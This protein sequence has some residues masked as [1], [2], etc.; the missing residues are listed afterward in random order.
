M[1]DQANVRFAQATKALKKAADADPEWF[2]VARDVLRRSDSGSVLLLHA[3]LDGLKEAYECGR[4]NKGPPPLRFVQS[5]AKMQE[6]A[7]AEREPPAAPRLRRAPQP[8]P[9]EVKPAPVRRVVRGAR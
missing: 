9:V 1:A 7:A 6:E 4:Q 5:I 3:L 2:D 8:K